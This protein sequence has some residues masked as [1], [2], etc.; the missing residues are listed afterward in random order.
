MGGWGFS[1]FAFCKPL[2]EEETQPGA[3]KTQSGGCSCPILCGAGGELPR[4]GLAGIAA[5]GDAIFIFK[6][7]YLQVIFLLLLK[8]YCKGAVS[9][10]SLRTLSPS[11][12]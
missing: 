12:A 10:F 2:L 1:V 5:E 6:S 7:I 9:F 3:I 4:V 8:V 11:L